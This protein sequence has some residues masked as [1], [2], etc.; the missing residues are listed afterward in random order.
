MSNEC[1]RGEEMSDIKFVAL[2]NTITK[3][4]FTVGIIVVT[5]LMH[6]TSLLF[7]LLLLP[8]LGYG[9]KETV[10]KK[11]DNSDNQEFDNPE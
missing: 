3:V 2:A 5:V 7:W 9:Y 1:R 11:E 10:N 6:K 4:V 8:F